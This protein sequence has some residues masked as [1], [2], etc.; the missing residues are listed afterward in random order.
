M[1]QVA[2]VT[3]LSSTETGTCKR[4]RIL[5]IVT[6]RQPRMK[7]PTALAREPL[8]TWLGECA[9]SWTHSF[10]SLNADW[11]NWNHNQPW[12]ARLHPSSWEQKSQKL[13]WA[14]IWDFLLKSFMLH[15]YSS[16]CCYVDLIA[17]LERKIESVILNHIHYVLWEV[18]RCNDSCRAFLK[19]VFNQK[20]VEFLQPH[21]VFFTFS[22]LFMIWFYE[23]WS[24][25]LYLLQLWTVLCTVISCQ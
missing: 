25:N 13:C 21:F 15:V 18:T 10:C 19:F 11:S 1:P 3:L 9:M 7:M 8:K 16:M 17:D 2:V 14:V 24:I 4:V 12:G 23:S 5:H 22:F 20:K 6:V